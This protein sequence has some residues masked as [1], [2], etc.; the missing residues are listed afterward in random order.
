MQTA[1][2]TSIQ[3]DPTDC[4]D[5]P[6][7]R[8]GAVTLFKSKK[9]LE[10]AIDSLAHEG[11][12]IC[13]ID[14]GNEATM[15]KD[16]AAALNWKEQFGYE[17]ASFNPD[18]FNDALSSAPNADCPKLLLV[19]N[20]YAGFQK[21]NKASA[22]Q[23]LDVIESCSRDHL[24]FGQRLLAFVRLGNPS[25]HIEGLGGRL[26]QWNPKEWLIKSRRA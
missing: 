20:R 11:Y 12:R 18:S 8:Y 1:K 23:L 14:L 9:V 2:S 10:Q 26:A 19:L 21:R 25:E 17:P 6:F 24:L 7:V 4:A 3:S 5:W 16:L 13:R 22:F 15:M